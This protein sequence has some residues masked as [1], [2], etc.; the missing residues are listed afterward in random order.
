[1]LDL[2]IINFFIWRF[3]N[4]KNGKLFDTVANRKQNIMTIII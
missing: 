4:N 1:M 3:N 2:N